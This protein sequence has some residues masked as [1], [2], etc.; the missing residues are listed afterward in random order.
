[1]H[2]I[3]LSVFHNLYCP[4]FKMCVYLYVC[5]TFAIGKLIYIIINDEIYN[6]ENGLKNKYC[7]SVDKIY[8]INRNTKNTCVI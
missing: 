3:L 8:N 5:T 6:Q 2:R 7:G 1:M 4:L